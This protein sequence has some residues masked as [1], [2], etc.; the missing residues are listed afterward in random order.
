VGIIPCTD[1]LVIYQSPQ[2]PQR[3]GR[4]GEYGQSDGY[5]GKSVN[6]SEGVLERC[7]RLD[8]RIEAVYDRTAS[9]IASVGIIEIHCVTGDKLDVSGEGAF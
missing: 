7:E 2:I 9:V 4:R 3:S 1:S 6:P 8:K 5:F